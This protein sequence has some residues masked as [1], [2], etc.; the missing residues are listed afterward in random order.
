MTTFPERLKELRQAKG[1]S[2]K[3]IADFLNMQQRAYQRYEYGQREPN[4]ETTIKLADCFD[5]S[6][7]YLLGRTDIKDVNKGNGT[8]PLN[9]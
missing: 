5:V 6:I 4:H 2:Q 9:K 1:L 8:T 7:D 3:Q